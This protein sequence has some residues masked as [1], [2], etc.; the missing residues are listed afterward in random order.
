MHSL[1]SINGL[2]QGGAYEMTEV[3]DAFEEADTFQ[4]SVCT[5]LSSPT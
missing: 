5:Y 4:L 1:S 2:A 3:A